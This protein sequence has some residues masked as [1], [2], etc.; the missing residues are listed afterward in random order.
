MCKPSPSISRYL[1][2]RSIHT[3]HKENRARIFKTLTLV[4]THKKVKWCPLVRKW[5][6]KMC[7]SHR[8]KDYIAA[9]LNEADAY[10]M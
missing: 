7:D 6:N 9:K 5:P 8:V 3:V 4:I 2:Q 1:L 10:N